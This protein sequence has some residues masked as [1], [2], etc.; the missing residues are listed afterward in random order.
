MAAE[1]PG[2]GHRRIHGELT[3]LGHTISAST[4]GNI[5]N[6]A[7]IDPAPRRSG[8]TRKQ[9]L[10]AQ[11]EHIIA[12]DFLHVDTIRLSTRSSPTPACG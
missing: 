6:R 1:N 2:W 12:V 7:G 11:A 10:T 8:P 4:V 3:R 5:L 9:F